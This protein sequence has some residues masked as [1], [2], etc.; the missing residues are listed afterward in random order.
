MNVKKP[1]TIFV[2]I[3]SLLLVNNLSA[4]CIYPTK[5]FV[6]PSGTN[7]TKDEMLEVMD[8]FKT[9]QAD[10]ESY[11][12]CLLAE[13]AAID[14]ASTS[15][16]GQEI[17]KNPVEK[18]L[19]K[20][21]PD[22]KFALN[23]SF[24]EGGFNM[25]SCNFTITAFDAYTK[26]NL[27]SKGG[28]GEGDFSRGP[29]ELVAEQVYA[30]MD[31]FVSDIQR[32]FEVLN[33]KNIGLNFRLDYTNPRGEGSQVSSTPCDGLNFKTSVKKPKIEDLEFEEDGIDSIASLA[34]E[35]NQNIENIGAR[36]LHTIMEKL[37]EEVSFNASDIGPKKITINKEFVEKNLVDLIKSQDLSKFI[38]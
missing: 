31:G 18:I 13:E 9:L 27:G 32:H 14:N 36:R 25:K 10:L 21:K 3:I 23:Y 16:D 29:G 1:I 5:D 34:T 30:H 20:A 7:S 11:R 24:T 2:S 8:K 22:I 17:A 26:K 6:I 12:S 15:K 35:I 28:T 4:E 38:L 37:L 33:K 19:E